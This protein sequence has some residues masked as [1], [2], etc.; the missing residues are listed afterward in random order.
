MARTRDEYLSVRQRFQPDPVK[1]VIVAESPPASGLY[2]YDPDGKVTEPLFSAL[3]KQIGASPQT[4][5]DGLQSL[6]DC[7]LI[8]VDATYQPV[9]LLS[10]RDRDRVILE[11]Y[12]QLVADLR[13]LA[14]A[15]GAPLVLIKANVCTL[16]EDR[17]L[18]DGLTVLNEGRKVY[19][20]ST[21]N[22][23]K[24]HEQFQVILAG[25]GLLPT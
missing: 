4:K 7:G 2:F 3:M 22:Q 16:L 21:G 14:A 24:F 8:L 20:P 12:P 23:T 6:K 9:N 19:F 17:L 13:R 11:D 15:N 10:A 18:G 1:L 25:T 5:R